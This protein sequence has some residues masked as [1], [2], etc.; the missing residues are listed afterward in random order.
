M[1]WRQ[2]LHLLFTLMLVGSVFWPDLVANCLWN[3]KSNLMEK[4]SLELLL[5]YQVHFASEI[6]FQDIYKAE[7]SRF[8]SILSGSLSPQSVSLL[9]MLT[10]R[11]VLS[12]PGSC[13]F[14]P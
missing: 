10:L 2:C 13:I 14:L 4:A 7:E 5:S 11:A 12:L 1:T 9:L 6:H 3:E 8:S